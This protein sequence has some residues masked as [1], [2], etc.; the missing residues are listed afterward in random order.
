MARLPGADESV[1]AKE[2]V[3]FG[4]RRNFATREYPILESSWNGM[5]E[6]MVLSLARLMRWA[7]VASGTRNAC[8]ISAVVRPPT[9]RNVSA[10]AE[11]R[12]NAGW[13]HMKGRT[14]SSCGQS[15]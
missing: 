7:I 3:K 10:I 4:A 15:R 1:R 9:A 14:R 11:A 2:E 8:A 13:Q 5:L 6:S 12:V